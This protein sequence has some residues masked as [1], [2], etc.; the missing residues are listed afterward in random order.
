MNEQYSTKV[1]S[2]IPRREIFLSAASCLFCALKTRGNATYIL[3]FLN[4]IGEKNQKTKNKIRKDIHVL[5][6]ISYRM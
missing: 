6:I 5:A 1:M 2:W 4:F 3:R